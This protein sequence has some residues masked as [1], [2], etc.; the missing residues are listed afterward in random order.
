MYVINPPPTIKV[1]LGENQKPES[2]P[3]IRFLE[4]FLNLT[5]W[6]KDF[7]SLKYSLEIS[8]AAKEADGGPF[9]ITDGPFEMLKGVVDNPAQG[10]PL[11]PLIMRQLIPYVRCILD[12]EEKGKAK[13]KASKK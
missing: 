8:E 6:N 3:F 11:H 7:K 2:W 4:A 9:E 12:A 1:K 10:Y 13:A 5:E